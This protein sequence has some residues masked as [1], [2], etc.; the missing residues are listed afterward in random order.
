MANDTASGGLNQ[1]EEHYSTFI[2]RFV[3]LPLNLLV[4]VLIAA[5]ADRTRFRPDRWCWPQLCSHPTAI[6]GYRNVGWRTLFAKDGLD[7]RFRSTSLFHSHSSPGTSSRRLD[8]R[9]STAF[10]LISISTLSLAVKM[11]GTIPANSAPSMCLMVP[12]ASPTLSALWII[13]DS[14]LNSSLSLSTRMS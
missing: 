14:W 13:F 5:C 2:V 1:L 10:A 3:P 4:S 12:W 11:D 8:G 7:V 6:L 9:A